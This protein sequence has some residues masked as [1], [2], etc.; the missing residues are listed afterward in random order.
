[1][2]LLFKRPTKASRIAK[3]K[4]PYFPYR[5]QIHQLSEDPCLLVLLELDAAPQPFS[6]DKIE[7]LPLLSLEEHHVTGAWTLADVNNSSFYPDVVS[8]HGVRNR[9]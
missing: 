6:A 1:M 5:V 7:L 4:N 8:H 3:R 9:S 2:L